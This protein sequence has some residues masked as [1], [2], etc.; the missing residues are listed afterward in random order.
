MKDCAVN[1]TTPKVC[2]DPKLQYIFTLKI[3]TE[4][5][6]RTRGFML[7]YGL[8]RPWKLIEFFTTESFLRPFVEKTHKD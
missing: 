6:G 7:P 8:A 2:V 5:G 3:T 1:L 4:P